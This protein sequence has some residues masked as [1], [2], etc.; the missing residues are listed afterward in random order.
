MQLRR[1][2]LLLTLGWMLV[3]FAPLPQVPIITLS[4]RSAFDGRFRDSQWMPIIVNVSNAGDPMTGRLVVRPETSGSGV[5]N[6]YRAPV[7]L[8]NGAEQTVT[9]YV[10]ARSF[11]SQ[12]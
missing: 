9:L 3:G 7:N 11:A 1:L 8:P 10:T 6:T 5:T 4:A 2:L 12:I